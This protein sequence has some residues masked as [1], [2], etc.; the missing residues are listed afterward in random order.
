VRRFKL[1]EEPGDDLSASTTA[2]Q[3]LA[4]MAALTN[5]AWL[6]AGRTV[7]DYPRSKAPVRVLRLR[8]LPKGKPRA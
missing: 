5:E 6:L 2:E 8:D 1:G 7:P 3:R 4:M